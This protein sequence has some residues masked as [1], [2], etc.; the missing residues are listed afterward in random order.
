MTGIPAFF[1]RQALYPDFV[2]LNQLIQQIL[3]MIGRVIAK[4]NTIHR[5]RGHFME[6]RST[7]STIC[8]DRQFHRHRS[9]IIPFDIVKLEIPPID[10]VG[11]ATC[12]LVRSGQQIFQIQNVGMLVDRTSGRV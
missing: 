3:G 10:Q 8:I 11:S 6:V 7:P 5:D 9:V 1:C 12:Q 4:M 2:V